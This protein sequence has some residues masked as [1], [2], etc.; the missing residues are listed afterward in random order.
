MNVKPWCEALSFLCEYLLEF[1][2]EL[3]QSIRFRFIPTP[4]ISVFF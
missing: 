3:S 2:L 1:L 4:F